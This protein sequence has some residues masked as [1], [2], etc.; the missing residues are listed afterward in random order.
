M[1]KLDEKQLIYFQNKIRSWYNKNGR[2]FYW[3]Q[4]KL[5][6]WE[7]IILESLLK[8]TKAETVEKYFQKVLKKYSTPD[9]VI[10]T[11]I[12]EIEQD[13]KIFGLYK[14][15]AKAFKTLAIL[16][17]VNKQFLYNDVK[18]PYM[19]EYIKNAI[20]CF[21]YEYRRAI[22]DANI[23]R[24]ITRY[25]NLDMPK[26]LRD[27]YFLKIANLILPQKNWI[28]YNYGIIDIGSIYCKKIPN[29]NKC[30]LKKRCLTYKLVILNS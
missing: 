1:I 11:D 28:E 27:D 9:D 15:R 14:Q 19:G 4:N 26:D 6:I 12:K 5:N 3:R 16:Y 13:I 17:D 29:C 25:F 22:V 21:Y 2:V 7:W 23:A 30:P 10:N 24:V 8:R 18:I 20:L